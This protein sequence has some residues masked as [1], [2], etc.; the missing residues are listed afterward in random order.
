MK[1][2]LILLPFLLSVFS[3][4]TSIEQIEMNGQSMYPTYQQDDII[5]YTNVDRVIERGDIV[6]VNYNNKTYIKR[7]IWIP[8][9]SINIREGKVYRKSES[10]ESFEKLDEEYLHSDMKDNT[11][12][13]GAQNNEDNIFDISEW[14]Y[15]LM[16]DN[17]MWSTDSRTCFMTCSIEWAKNTIWLDQIQWIVIDNNKD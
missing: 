4:S 16:W 8:W 7:V 3:C 6:V 11:F 12:I 1:K 10:E 15:F 17:R 14:E 5:F 2:I 9:D 13:R